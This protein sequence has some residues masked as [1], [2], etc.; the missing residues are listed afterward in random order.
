MSH[1]TVLGRFEQQFELINKR[2]PLID[3]TITDISNSA[4]VDIIGPNFWPILRNPTVERESNC[5]I[6]NYWIPLFQLELGGMN[7]ELFWG[8][9]FFFSIWRVIY[10]KSHPCTG[11]GA[12]KTKRDLHSRIALTSNIKGGANSFLPPISFHFFQE[13]SSS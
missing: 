9:T 4:Y 3:K 12:R 11:K 6:L 7:P 2:N 10:M 5:K 1:F 13:I 8:G